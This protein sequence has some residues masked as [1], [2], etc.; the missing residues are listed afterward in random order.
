LASRIDPELARS[1]G[2]SYQ[3]VLDSD[4]RAVPD[5]LRLTS[6]RFL[7]SD[8]LQSHDLAVQWPRRPVKPTSSPA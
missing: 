3:E 6:P 5:V 2:I 4:T 1:P 7:G 8:D